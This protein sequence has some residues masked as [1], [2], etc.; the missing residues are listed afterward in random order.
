MSSVTR[1]SRQFSDHERAAPT[2]QKFTLTLI[3]VFDFHEHS[4]V[5]ASCTRPVK[6]GHLQPIF[7]RFGATSQIQSDIVPRLA[8]IRA[9]DD[10]MVESVTKDQQI[11]PVFKQVCL[12]FQ[13][14]CKASGSGGREITSDK[15]Y[16]KTAMCSQPMIISLMTHCWSD[17]FICKRICHFQS[18]LGP[19]CD[20]HN[21]LKTGIPKNQSTIP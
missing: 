18:R 19:K 9:I 11:S 17:Y 8:A 2:Q 5:E 16:Q 10:K 15:R 6:L 7:L 12:V 13:R 1:H 3:G 21:Y 14:C 4:P 20:S